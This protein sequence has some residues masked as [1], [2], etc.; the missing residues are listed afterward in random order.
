VLEVVVPATLERTLAGAGDERHNLGN[1]DIPADR[2]DLLRLGQELA[3]AVPQ[4]LDGR[5]DLD[6]GAGR[7]QQVDDRL[8]RRR[9]RPPI[10][11]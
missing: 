4:G 5:G 1:L 11:R 9:T 6:I 3:Y 7:G 10:P 2:A 8:L